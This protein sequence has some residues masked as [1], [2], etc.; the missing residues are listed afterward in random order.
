MLGA[1][2]WRH[3]CSSSLAAAC[4]MHEMTIRLIAV[5][6]LVVAGVA[7]AAAPALPGA[8]W[9]LDQIKL[10]SAPEMDG[11]GSGTPGADRA[12]RHIADVFRAAGLR[13]GGDGRH[14]SPGLQRA[15]RHAARRRQH[16]GP[17]RARGPDLHARHRLHA[18]GRLH[19]RRR[20]RARSSSPATASPRPICSTTTTRGST[21]RDRIVIVLTGD[22]RADDPAS[23]FRRPEAY[24]YSQR[25]HKIINAREHGARAIL[26]VA[27]PRE[28]DDLPALRGLS[29]AHGILAAFVTRS[30]AD[31]LLAAVGTDRGRAGRRHRSRAGAAVVRAGRGPVSAG[32][33]TLVRERAT[34]AN[35]D[36]HPAGRRSAAAGRGDR[37]RRALRPPRPRRRGLAGPGV[38][39]PG[40]SRRRRQR[41][42]HHRRAGARPR[43][44][45]LGAAPAHARLRHLRR[46]GAG[47]ARLGPLRDAIRRFRSTA[48]C[49]W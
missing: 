13:P 40:P 8:E 34:T 29:Q 45:R 24:H 47:P 27:H 19:R 16:A 9:M 5:L 41:L 18:A 49:S 26:L 2:R 32:E 11:R 15:D 23:P 46:R 21:A 4:T 6:L 14:L 35:V 1:E 42:R 37:D 39:R 17:A 48:P 12:A 36:R 22:P 3:R 20:P 33:V 43:V 7:Q 28:R 25:T 31:A 44:R 10:L 38:D 30:T